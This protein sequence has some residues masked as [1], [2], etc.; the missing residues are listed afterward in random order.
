MAFS[1]LLLVLSAFSSA[2]A[3]S[4][5]VTALAAA[6]IGKSYPS[7]RIQLTSDVQWDQAIDQTA[8][9]SITLSSENNGRAFLSAAAQDE[10]GSHIVN[11][12]VMFNAMVPAQIAVRRIQPG[13][14]LTA[15]LFTS[16]EVNV[17]SGQWYAYRGLFMGA[18]AQVT[19]LQTRQTILEGQPLLSSAIEKIPDVRRGDEIQVHLVSGALT[20]STIG[21][22]EETGYL[23][24][25]IRVMTQKTKRELVGKLLPGN[26]VEVKL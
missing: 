13:E 16:Q 24:N 18:N 2:H 23:N 1:F 19:G 8:I 26:V 3:D 12:S 21:V 4:A 15:S 6:E 25:P 5:T 17:S 14:P 11:G 22:S 9:R 10:N 7:A 20:L